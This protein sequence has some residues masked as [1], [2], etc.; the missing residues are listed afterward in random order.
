M[1]AEP[2]RQGISQVL[3]D[4]DVDGAKGLSD[5]D[6]AERQGRYG[7][8]VLPSDDGVN[9]FQLI[10]SQ[11]TDVMVIVLIVAAIIS[12]FLGEA[13][14][15]IVILAIVA[16]NALLGIYQEYQAEQALAALSRL[17]V[18]QVRVRRGGQIREI[19]AEELTPGDIVLIGEGDR[20]PADGRL[21]E[22]IN[23]QIEEAALTGESVPVEKSTNS[24]STEGAVPI[25]DRTNM[26]YMGTAVNYGRGEMVVTQT[27]LQTEIG[28]IAT[29][30]LQVQGGAT[31]LQRRL[32]HLGHILATAALIVVAI[33]FFVGFLIQGIPAEQMFL[34]AISLA[35]AAVPE[36][37]PA[38][39]TIGL[40]LGANRMVK[41]NVLIRRL[42]AVETL[43]SVTVICSDKTGTLTKN[44]MTATYLVLPRH[45]DIRVEGAGY[46]AEGDLVSLG[47]RDP[48]NLGK[49]V[50]AEND[51]AA[52][53]MLK[54]MALSTNVYLET[55]DAGNQVKV[56]GDSTEAALLVA[57]QKIGFTRERLEQDMPR[58]SELPFSSERKAMTTVHEVRSD[59]AQQLFPDAKYVVITKGAP[60]RLIDWSESEQTPDAVVAL[61]ESGRSRWQQRVNT[62]ANDGLRVLGIAW[63]PLDELPTEITPEIERDLELIGLIGIL[64]PARPEAKVAV[65]RAREAGIRTIMITG[66]HALTAEAIARDLG[67]I[68]TGQRAITGSALDDMG[69]AELEVALQ[70]TSCFARVSPAHK[71]RLVQVLQEQDKIVAMTGDGVNDAPA[72]K[73][74]DIGVAMGITGADVSKGASEMILTDDNF[75]S[76]VAAIEEGRAIYDNIKKFI[77]YM[78]SS[79]VGEIL[80]MFVALLINMPIPLL[81]IQ[82][83]WINLVTDGLPAIALGFEPAEEGVMRRRP[84]PTNESVFAQGAGLHI[85]IV[86]VL[87]AILTLIS[88]A[89]GYTTIGLDAFNPSLGLER[90]ER[91]AVVD[92]A[93]EAATPAAW[94]EWTAEQRTA[95]L[96]ADAEAGASFLEGH[97]EG[98]KDPGRHLLAQAERVPRTIAFTVLAF[99]QMFQVMAIHAGDQT[100]FWRA[101]VKGNPL[102]FWAVLSTFALQLFVVYVPFFQELF[103]TRALDLTHLAV[104]VVAGIF[105]LLFVEVEKAAFRRWLFAGNEAGQSPALS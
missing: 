40:S 4:L 2:Y 77:K 43:G 89:W 17:Q 76:I 80:V 50:N 33:V 71:L 35:V 67:I 83:L 104:S 68:D 55:Q 101:G 15:V 58:V 39:V 96:V 18:P 79:N 19:S 6:A 23:L 87:I 11:F 13:T 49:P 44:E 97:G 25:G 38:L 59:T 34:I 82:I 102:M 28:N 3:A 69:D 54:A 95:F 22:S 42:P 65:Q 99:T 1:M 26:A 84:R 31:P 48:A 103:D 46:V 93:G 51:E 8:N 56:V 10:I 36:G 16:L 70:R 14:D 62:M 37:L 5:G 20:I 100:T 64:D 7:R 52:Q 57:A 27:G 9:W 75:R 90:L 105:V 24:I 29:M 12:A 92:L 32:N 66:D 86:G 45:D 41:R 53:R 78:L 81:A 98:G 88:Y 91:A 47:T 21:I 60:D 30:L 73:Q 63:R 72:L 74:A 94:D 85:A 61:S